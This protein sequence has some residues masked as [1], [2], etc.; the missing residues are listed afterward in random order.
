MDERN[1]SH[2]HDHGHRDGDLESISQISTHAFT[3]PSTD[4]FRQAIWY[5]L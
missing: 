5:L 1:E 3:M 2:V 4:S